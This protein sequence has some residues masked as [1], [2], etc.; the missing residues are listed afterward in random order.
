[1]VGLF[2]P[3]MLGLYS[4]PVNGRAAVASMLVGTGI[5]AIH[6][7]MGWDYFLAPLGAFERMRLPLSLGATALAL[8]AYFVC[9]PPWRI[10][11][12][13]AAQ[14]RETP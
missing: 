4:A 3:L 5:W 13:R 11:W 14:T 9:E 6:F 2:V 10:A 7:L 12:S 8:V 1:M